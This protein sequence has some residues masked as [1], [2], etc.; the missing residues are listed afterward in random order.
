[1]SKG[2][3]FQRIIPDNGPAGQNPSGVKKV[4]FC[5]GRVYYDLTKARADQKL[6]NDIAIIRVE[7]VNLSLPF[8]NLVYSL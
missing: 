6:E 3:E 8:F 1:M 7:Q 4:V 2:T 5:S